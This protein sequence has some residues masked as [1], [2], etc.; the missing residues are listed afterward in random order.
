MPV[1]LEYPLGIPAEI[2]D[3]RDSYAGEALNQVYRGNAGYDPHNIFLTIALF[4][5]FF[6]VFGLFAFYIVTIVQAYLGLKRYGKNAVRE[7]VILLVLAIGAISALLVH[8]WFHNASILLGEMRG[9]IWF[10]LAQGLLGNV[11]RS[12]SR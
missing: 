11:R 1:I 8:S 6:A 12:A 7:D 2:Y 10:G 4:Y 5:G 9:W 3:K